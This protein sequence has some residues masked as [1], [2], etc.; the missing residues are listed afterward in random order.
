MNLL[1]RFQGLQIPEALDGNNVRLSRY[2]LGSIVTLKK[3]LP[4][5]ISLF[6]LLSRYY[7]RAT[8]HRKK[9]IQIIVFPYYRVKI[10]LGHFQFDIKTPAIQPLQF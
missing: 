8:T 2:I 10:L 4:Y 6:K 9:G 3:P 7:A 5:L 1:R